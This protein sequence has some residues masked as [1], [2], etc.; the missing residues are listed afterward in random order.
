MPVEVLH[1][2]SGC[3]LPFV[4]LVALHGLRPRRLVVPVNV[5][6]VRLDDVR[7]AQYEEI[8]L[9]VFAC[10]VLCIPPCVA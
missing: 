3:I 10:C 4:C 6:A 8:G 7:V 5:Q 9:V 2:L 1:L